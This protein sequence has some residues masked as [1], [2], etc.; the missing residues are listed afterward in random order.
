MMN[1]L[2]AAL[3]LTMASTTVLADDQAFTFG[4]DNYISGAS[5]EMEAESTRD[6]FLSGF[7]TE[8]SAKA[9]GDVHAMG[10]N[11]DIDAETGEDLYL[12]GFSI[13][14]TKPVG[15]DLSASG[16]N[17]EIEQSANIGGNVRVFGG[18]VSLDAP[19]GG[20][21]LA[22]AGTLEI[23]SA[24]AGDA[25]LTAGELQFGPNASIGGRLHYSAAEPVDI[26]A[27]VVPADRVTFS[28]LDVSAPN[29]MQ[30][31]IEEHM[32]YGAGSFLGGFFSFVAAIVFLTAVAAAFLALMPKRCEAYRD[33]AIA[34]PWRALLVGVVGLAALIGL[35]PVSAMTV[36]GLPLIPVII[37][38]LIVL[39]A[40]AYLIG[41]FALTWRIWVAFSAPPQVLGGKLVVV[42]A[43]LVVMALINFIPFVGW[44]INLALVLAGF[45]VMTSRLFDR[46]LMAQLPDIASGEAE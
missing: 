39:W 36:I 1:R 41:V 15:D 3:L 29:M 13:T 7:S 20:S 11:V 8:L 2:F 42:V 17:I 37:L 23:N 16:A 22:A 12:A 28:K 10:F 38:A 27:S 24:I 21:L 9:A 35:I 25:N 44:L 19:V 31:S 43:G 32:D 5:V 40:L 4:G 30:E 14:V 46:I 33:Q 18:K 45:G 34:Q 6:V 26:P